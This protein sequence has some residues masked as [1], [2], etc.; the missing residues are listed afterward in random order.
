MEVLGAL[1]FVACL[2]YV[3]ANRAFANEE[4]LLAI[5]KEL[6]IARG[7]QSSTLPQS[8]PTRTELEIAALRPHECGS[9]RFLRFPL[10]R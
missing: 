6:E 3:S 9:R 8:V 7:I 4:R 10:P 1:V 5:D 2:G